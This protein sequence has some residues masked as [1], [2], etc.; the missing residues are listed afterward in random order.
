MAKAKLPSSTKERI[1]D[2]A[3]H[4][5]AERGFA[6]TSLRD[7]T[8]EAGANLAAVNYYFQSKDALIQ[9]VFAR[10]IGPVNERRLAM[11]DAAEAKAGRR[12]VPLRNLVRAFI[13]PVVKVCRE[14]EGGN[15]AC[16]LGRA[17][18]E[19][20]DVFERLFQRQLSGVVRRFVAA[21][22]RALPR[23]GD[24]E[25]FWRFHF[26]VG[27]M[28]HTLAGLR[29]IRVTSGGRCDVSD[30]DGLVERLIP[31]I[32]A[33]LKAPAR[34]THRGGRKCTGSR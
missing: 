28:G 26:A 4:L 6:S 19:P 8:A 31:F 27:V 34:A 17:F 22:R 32:A 12:P 16:L 7:I 33:G 18:V 14:P 29:H 10:R 30:A 2:A 1:L 9:A 20:G 13:E 5:F 11:L 3:E 23:V 15:A 25:L 24:T 21:F